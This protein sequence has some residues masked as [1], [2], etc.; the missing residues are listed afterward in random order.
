MDSL[1][2]SM[3]ADS[4]PSLEKRARNHFMIGLMAEDLGMA[5]EA[6]SNYF[7]AL[8]AAADSKIFE[9]VKD[10]P[11]DH[12]ERLTIL[13]ARIPVLYDITDRLSAIH[14]RS[15]VKDLDMTEARVI[16]NKVKEAFG[17][18]G[19]PMPGDDEI[20]KK[21]EELSKRKSLV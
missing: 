5:Q 15:L 1:E 16:R 2:E 17:R 12:S 6:A 7:E 20:R 14:K 13:K 18:A 9:L 19:I 3:K 10:R 8:F 11:N 21:L 4:S